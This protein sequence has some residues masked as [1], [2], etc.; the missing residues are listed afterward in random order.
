[1]QIDAEG[2][3]PYFFSFLPM[4]DV[5]VV[6]VIVVVVVGVGVEGR[7]EAENEG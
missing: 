2:I 1:M 3:L 4:R 7:V 5:V 6:I